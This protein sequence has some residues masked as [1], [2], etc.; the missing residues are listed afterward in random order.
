M[1]DAERNDLLDDVNRFPRRWTAQAL[2]DALN[3]TE[4][5]RTDLKVRTIGSVDVTPRERKRLS[6]LRKRERDRERRRIRRR[7]D[8]SRT[9]AQYLADVKSTEPWLAA[10]MRRATYYLRR[11]IAASET[12][13]LGASPIKFSNASDSPSPKEQAEVP[14]VRWGKE[15]VEQQ[16]AS[17]RRVQPAELSNPSPSNASGRKW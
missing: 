12:V 17:Y 9:R 8:G 5:E 16:V 15:I 7:D 14:K 6:K 4:A 2:A 11:K 1:T 10:G 3:L 13:G